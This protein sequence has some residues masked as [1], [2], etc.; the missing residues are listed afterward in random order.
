MACSKAYDKGT[1]G[2]FKLE[3]TGNGMI[4]LSSKNYDC[5]GDSSYKFSSEGIQKQMRS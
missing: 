3:Y 5:W 4:A 2:L 1:P